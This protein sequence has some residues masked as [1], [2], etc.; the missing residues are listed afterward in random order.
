MHMQEM[1]ITRWLTILLFLTG[2][3]ACEKAEP[4][5]EIVWPMKET[6]SRGTYTVSIQPPGESA[7]KQHEHFSLELMLVPTKEPNSKTE[8]KKVVIAADMP[9]HQHGMNTKPEL[10]KTGPGRYRVD[11][12]LF[13]MAG[14]WVVTVKIDPGNGKWEQADFP[15]LIE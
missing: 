14:D 8:A 2:L 11:G 6:S 13:H 10:T 5:A 3:G 9:T 1:K 12:M 7:I 15:I 4:D